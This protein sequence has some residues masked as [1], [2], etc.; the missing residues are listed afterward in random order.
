VIVSLSFWVASR[1]WFSQDD[2]AFLAY[3]QLE[4][5][6]SWLRV[7]L[8]IEERFWA[9]YRPLSMET[10]FWLGYRLFGLE[11]FGFFAISLG[12]HFLGAGL[13]Y[14]LARQFGFDVRVASATA[15]LA[16]SRHGSLDEIYYGS[17][18]M[19]VG[20][21]FFSLASITFFLDYLRSGRLAAQLASCAGLVLALLCNE[22]AAA[23][24]ALLAWVALGAGRAGGGLRLLRALSPQTG[25]TV[26]YLVFR[27]H[28]IA[29]APTL[30]LVSPELYTLRLGAHVPGNYLQ[31]LAFVFGGTRGLLIALGLATALFAAVLARWDARLQGEPLRVAL[32]CVAW[33]ATLL[34]P[35]AMLPFPQPRWAMPLAAPVCL[36]FGALLEAFWRRFSSRGIRALELGLVALVL[37]AV[38][39]GALL[40]RAADPGGAHPR[41]IV[42]WIDAQDPPLSS[43]AVLVLLYEAP[44]LAG[45]ADAERFRYLSYGGGVLNAAYPDTQRVM[46][47]LDLS[48]RPPR[49]AMRPDSVY[50]ALDPAL[51]VARADPGLLDRQLPR[52]F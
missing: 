25:L 1:E 15:L 24:P 5:T 18:F 46:R 11:A 45:A 27:F 22:V 19:Y 6:W 51:G 49:N 39:V 48:R 4:E 40:E 12:L 43:R 21:V 2:F 41:S 3:V 37:A 38:P 31:I 8:P 32:A 35:F 50:L 16:V 14:R 23:T 28:W 26:L 20:Q 9:F 47:F 13:V 42:E 44:G 33:T 34:A 17:V 7:F 29:P 36:L 52:R 30:E 10:F